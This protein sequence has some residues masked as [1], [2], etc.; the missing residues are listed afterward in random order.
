MNKLNYKINRKASSA[1]IVYPCI[2]EHVETQALLL[3]HSARHGTV[4][5]GINQGKHYTALVSC[6]FKA[7]VGNVVLTQE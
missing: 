1:L 4:L 7:F 6:D 2:R 3:L 5:T